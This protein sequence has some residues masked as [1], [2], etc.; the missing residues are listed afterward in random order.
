MNINIFL[1]KKYYKDTNVISAIE[2]YKRRCGRFVSI[3]LFF[4]VDEKLISQSMSYNINVTQNG[5]FMDS[6]MFSESI[7]KCLLGRIKNLNILF[8]NSMFKFNK[9]ICF[10][11][12][13]LLSTGFLYVMIIE[14]IYRAYKII[15]NEPY[16]K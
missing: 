13:D 15:N 10:C 11:N 16:H 6:R 2:D 3:K 7:N 4:N 12:V 5:M 1:N 14:Q 8:E 9:E